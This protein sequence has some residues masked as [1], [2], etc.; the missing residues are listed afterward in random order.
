MATTAPMMAKAAMIA[1]YPDATSD[2]RLKL[3]AKIDGPLRAIT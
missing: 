1:A 2:E 3:A